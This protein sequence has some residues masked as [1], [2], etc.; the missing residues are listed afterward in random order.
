M[1]AKYG[2]VGSD[3]GGRCGY[4]AVKG[5]LYVTLSGSVSA[6]GKKSIVRRAV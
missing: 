1:G 6:K 2:S 4:S 3:V 5:D